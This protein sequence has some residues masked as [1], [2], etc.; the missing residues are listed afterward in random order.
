MVAPLGR[1]VRP[2]GG[3]LGRASR[4]LG[5][6]RALRD[7]VAPVNG[8]IGPI[9]G[10]GTLRR[11]RPHAV[12][13]VGSPSGGLEGVPEVRAGGGIVAHRRGLRRRAGRDREIGNSRHRHRPPVLVITSRS[14]PIWPPRSRVAAPYFS[15]V[16]ASEVMDRST[17]TALPSF[18]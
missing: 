16:S 3:M 15:C 11:D 2:L 13:S 17:S 12:G 7:G 8:P 10:R 5:E 1:I 14:M 4:A 6:L 9:R 18:R